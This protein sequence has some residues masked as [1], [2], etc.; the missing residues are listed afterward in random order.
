MPGPPSLLW[1]YIAPRYLG[2]FVPF[3]AL[4]SA[5]AMADIW[6][7]LEGRTGS[8]CGPVHSVVIGLVALF[9]IVANFGMAIVP[10]EEWSTTQTLNFV[11]AQKTHQRHHRAPA[12]RPT[13]FAGP[14]APSVGTGRSALRGRGL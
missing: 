3:L 4:A 11:E 8:S 13:S 9:S 10:N 1:G 14:I 2:D 12:R 6:R 5:V 7:R